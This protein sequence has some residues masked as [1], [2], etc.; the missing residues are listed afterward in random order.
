MGMKGE[1]IRRCTQVLLNRRTWYPDQQ[2]PR[3]PRT[4]QYDA[5]VTQHHRYSSQQWTATT[6]Y[7]QGEELRDE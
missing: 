4:G 1:F 5:R 7:I 2:T 6:R 3:Q